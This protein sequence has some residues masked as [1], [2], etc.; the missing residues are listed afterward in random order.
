MLEIWLPLLSLALLGWAWYHV[1]RLRE[2]AVAHARRLCD[3]RGL[4]LLDDSVSLHRLRASWRNGGLH[5]LREYRFDTSLGG[6]DRQSASVTLL[7]GRVVAASLPEATVPAATDTRGAWSGPMVQTA[8][9]AAS[10]GKVV[11]IERARRTLH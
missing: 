4:Q 11:P 3:Q 6:H 1:L 5:V 2:R 8:P 10:T 7:G 9:G